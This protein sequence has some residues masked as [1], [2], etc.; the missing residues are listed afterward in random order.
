MGSLRMTALIAVLATV[1]Q[2]AEA[3]VPAFV[4][5][6]GLVCNQCHM[7]W[8]TAP[9]FTFTGM[10]FRLNGY[11]TPWVSEKVEAGEEGAVNGQRL[12]LTL[13]SM[14]SWHVRG[15]LLGG[16]TP[17]SDPSLAAPSPGS[18][19]T[20]LISTAAMHYAGPIGEHVGIWNEFYMY[21]G[22]LGPTAANNGQGGNR[23]GYIGLSHFSVNLTTNSGGNIYGFKGD[24]LPA[25]AAHAFMQMVTD[26]TPNHQLN[27]PGIVGGGSPYVYWSVW[28]FWADRLGLELGVEPGEDNLDFKK[29]NYRL[30]SGFFL[31]NTDHNWIRLAYQIKAGNDMVPIVSS[32]KASNDG[33]RTLVPVDAIRGISATRSSGL[34]LSSLDMGDAVR[35]QFGPGWG[36]IDHGPHSFVVGISQVIEHETYNDNSSAKMAAIGGEAR[37]YYNRTYGVELDWNTY[38]KY[39]F[40]DA[41]G[42]VHNMPSYPNWQ[43]QLV[44]RLAMNFAWFVVFNNSQNL[45]LDQKWRQGHAWSI[46][47]QY[48]W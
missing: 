15:L 22:G 43:V 10:K 33:V 36:F 23:N 48:L 6:T 28:G 29:F 21:G 37:Y 4:R 39:S 3:R 42:V 30:E 24:L 20:N 47:M 9:D 19:T 34:P 35:M 46:N 2:L 5:Q 7:S 1:P 13:G 16:S 26:P 45:V 27:T 41:N 44:Y 12:V 8:T 18:P 25:S 11:R 17:A 14:L 40:T 31:K 38:E 32:L